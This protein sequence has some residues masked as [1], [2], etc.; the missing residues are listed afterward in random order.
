MD[1][2]N[3]LLLNLF[4]ILQICHHAS[5]KVYSFYNFYAKQ[6]ENKF[7]NSVKATHKVSKH[8]NAKNNLKFPVT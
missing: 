6:R 5:K 4:F 2:I 7:M 8:G 1:K 3:V